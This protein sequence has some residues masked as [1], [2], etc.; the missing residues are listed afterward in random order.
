MEGI[1][2]PKEELKRRFGLSERLAVRFGALLSKG[3]AATAAVLEQAAGDRELAAFVLSPAL[4]EKAAKLDTP[5]L[6]KLSPAA[7]HLAISDGVLALDEEVMAESALAVLPKSEPGLLGRSEAEKLFAPDDVSR[8]KLALLTEVDPRKK[9]LALRQAS[10]AP[11]SAEERGALTLHALGDADPEVRREAAALL[12]TVGLSSALAETLSSLADPAPRTRIQAVQKLSAANATKTERSIVL[13]CLLASLRHEADPAVLSALLDGLSAYGDLLCAGEPLAGLA[14]ELV[15]RMGLHLEALSAPAQR[16]LAALGRTG[17]VEPAEAVWREVEGIADRPL[18]VF[19]ATAVSAMKHAG[20]FRRRFAAAVA[21]EL[22]AGPEDLASRRLVESA[23]LMGDDFLRALLEAYPAVPGDSRGGF[24][25]IVDSVATTDFVGDAARTDAGRLLVDVLRGAPRA[26]RIL[27]MESRLCADPRL[28][29]DVKRD[30]CLDFLTSLH[31]LRAERLFDVTVAT[32]RRMGPA[33]LPDLRK[34]IRESSYAEERRAAALAMS[35]IALRDENVDSTIRFFRE[36]E[37]G[38][39]L[40]EGLAIREVGRMCSS[41]HAGAKLVAEVCRDTLKRATGGTAWLDAI[42]ALGWIGAAPAC[43]ASASADIALRLLDLLEQDLPWPEAKEEKTEE[44]LRFVVSAQSA[45]FTDLLPDVIQGVARIACSGKLAPGTVGLVVR[46]L[47]SKF[48][49]LVE[50]REVWAP[51]NVVEL[52]RALGEIARRGKTPVEDRVHAAETLFGNIR[53]VTTAR[54]LAEVL[55]EDVPAKR[56]GDLAVE[57]ANRMFRMLESRDYQEIDDRMALVAGLGRLA[58]NR[59]LKKADLRARAIEALL[60]EY[61]PGFA[62]AKSVLERLAAS[63]SIDKDLRRRI[64]SA[65]EG[66]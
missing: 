3:L 25:A 21:R 24:L 16:L 39:L 33:I 58:L 4:L 44:G 59:G 65:L 10:L 38:K 15:K 34:R 47:A 18:R 14:R 37:D 8:L 50:Y 12:R 52:A 28:G 42:A 1:R 6:R 41:P 45:V 2:L 13:A 26:L 43:A 36:L 9:I 63:K 46:R 49:A 40:P 48:V 20:G 22:A 17:R 7:R 23:K 66:A 61:R 56:W 29:A 11:L 55:A 64:A 51:G 60:G 31:A 27:V 35:E 30:L 57:A 54:V 62:E 53:N 32:L 5:A 19:F